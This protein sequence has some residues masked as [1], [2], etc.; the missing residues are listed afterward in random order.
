MSFKKLFSFLLDLNKNNNKEWMDAH[1]KEYHAVRDWYKDWLAELDA[2]LANVD[3]NYTHTPSKKAINRINNN[4][5]FHPNRPIYKDHLGA[6]LDMVKGT[7]DFYIHLGIN[8]CLLCSGFYKPDS[9]TLRSIREAI[10]YNGEEL[11]KILN[12]RAFKKHFPTLFQDET[13]KTVPKGFSKDHPHIDLLRN[14]SFAVEH[15][16]TQEQ[17][18]QNNFMDYVIE[19][20]KEVLPFRQYLNE[21]V[22]V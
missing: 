14:K 8:E 16:I 6:G 21:A 5:M 17:V 3:P 7:C 11:K 1:R 2:K 12:K 22:T 9:K 10:D 4:L 19:V 18:M 15:K 20:Y 13:L